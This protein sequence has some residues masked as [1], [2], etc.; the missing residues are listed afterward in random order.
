MIKL[1]TIKTQKGY[2]EKNLGLLC[3]ETMEK[4]TKGELDEFKV[5]SLNFYPFSSRSTHEYSGIIY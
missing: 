1:E 2:L 4:L 3:A 5:G